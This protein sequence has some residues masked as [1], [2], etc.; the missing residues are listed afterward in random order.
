M[1]YEYQV[2]IIMWFVCL[3]VSIPQL[4]AVIIQIQ[5]HC[6]TK[7]VNDTKKKKNTDSI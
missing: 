6:Q 1:H 3:F 4:Y 5:V 7:S 2:N